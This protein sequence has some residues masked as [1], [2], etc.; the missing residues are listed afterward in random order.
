MVWRW[1]FGHR[2]A[3]GVIF[4]MRHRTSLPQLLGLGLVLAVFLGA[5]EAAEAPLREQLDAPLLFTKRH[6]YQ[7]IHIYD[8][9]YQWW[10]GGGIYILENP[11]D[12][13]ERHRIRSVIDAT[14]PETLGEGVYSDPELSWDAT[15]ILFCFK[16]EKDGS[17]NIYEIGIDG[18]GLRMITN[19]PQ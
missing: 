15:R 10:P 6:S 11:A 2:A 14:T 12:P 8:T 18:T 17:T 4:M 3:N 19:E 9:Y 16:G 1:Q 13:P 7:G 5:A